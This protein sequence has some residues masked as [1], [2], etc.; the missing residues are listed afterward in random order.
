[1]FK[2]YPAVAFGYLF[3]SHVT[4]RSRPDSDVDVA[5]WIPNAPRDTLRRIRM[6]VMGALMHALHTDAIDVVL[7]NTAPLSLRYVVQKHGLLVDEKDSELRIRFEVSTRLE[8]WDFE[9]YLHRYWQ[10]LKRMIQEG[11]FGTRPA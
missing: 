4:E 11:T 9:P 6:E 5:I 8:Y 7:L 2:Q 1:M 10:A 3:G